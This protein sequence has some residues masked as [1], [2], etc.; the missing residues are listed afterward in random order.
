MSGNIG[1]LSYT[2]QS[3]GSGWNTYPIYDYT[4]EPIVDFYVGVSQPCGDTS[5]A[6]AART[7]PIS[8]VY[9]QGECTFSMNGSSFHPNYYSSGYYESESALYQ[10]NLL[11][12]VIADRVPMFSPSEL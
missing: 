1:G 2:Q 4:N 9:Q 8:P 5:E 3:F 11:Y 6:L 10:E 12:P 7:S